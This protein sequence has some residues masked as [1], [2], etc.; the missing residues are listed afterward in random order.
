MEKEFLERCLSG[1]L[2]L[3]AIGERVEKHPSTVGYW[4]KKHGL[5]AVESERNAPKGRLSK[6]ELAALLHEGISLRQVAERL[7][8]SLTTV[9]YWVDK[10]G[11]TQARNAT[12]AA[13]KKAIRKCRRHGEGTFVL[14]GRGY[15][16][17]ASCRAEAVARRR[18]AIKSKLVEEAGGQ[19]SICAY[20][21]CHRALQFHHVDP[22]TKQFHLGHN[23]I[24]RSLAKSRIEAR[25]CVLL[26]ANCHAE[27]EAG[28]VELPLDS[29]GAANPA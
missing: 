25:K 27:V 19:C 10:Y 20:S 24:T 16:R 6:S 23:G 3:E 29:H 9:R 28:L 22:A 15:Y 12:I 4:L 14:E 17:C 2:S 8:R 11:L 21:R 18:R 1:G 13:P 7:G 5:S 26:C